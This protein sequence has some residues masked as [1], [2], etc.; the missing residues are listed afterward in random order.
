[1]TSSG[2]Q[3]ICCCAIASA[4][5]TADCLYSVGYL[6]TSRSMRRY[7]SGD[8]IGD[9]CGSALIVVA[10]YGAARHR[11]ALPTRSGKRERRRPSG[12]PK[13]ISLLRPPPPRGGASAFGA[14]PRRSSVDLAEHDV[15]RADDRNRV[16][17]HV[18]SRHL[19]ERLQVRKAGR[20]YL[21][22]VRLVGAVRNQ[23]DAEFALW[24]LDRGV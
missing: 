17:D 20:P 7:D 11:C 22:P 9:G 5:M 10:P 14:A 2:S 6:A 15:L 21:Q 16:G 23:I 13:G 8:S 12:M 19:V 24:M 18:A 1:M 4:A 3:P